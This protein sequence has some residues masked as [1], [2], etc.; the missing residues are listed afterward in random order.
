[1][2]LHWSTGHI[3]PMKILLLRAISALLKCIGRMFTPRPRKDPTVRI[4]GID[5]EMT[6]AIAAARATLPNYWQPLKH[7]EHGESQFSLKVKI[8]DGNTA[9]H[10]WAVDVTYENGIILGTIDNNPDIIKIVKL[11]QRIQIREQDITDWGYVRDGRMFGKY[12][13]RAILNRLPPLDAA[14]FRRILSNEP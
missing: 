10:F 1:M 7:R 12:T 2:T 5:T 8:S 3:S 13:L 11:G 14:K 6:A 9:E 4:E